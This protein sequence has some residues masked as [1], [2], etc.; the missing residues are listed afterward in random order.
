MELLVTTLFLAL[1]LV[2]SGSYHMLVVSRNWFSALAIPINQQSMGSNKTWRGIVVMMLATIPGVYLCHFLQPTL[3]DYLIVDM[4]LISPLWMGVLLGIGYVVPE[5]PN[6]YIKRKFNIKPGEQS[7]KYSFLF[8]F[9]DQADSAIGCAFVYGL[10]LS[11]PFEIMVAMI[12]LGPLLHVIA[13]ILL[14]S[15][16]LRKQPL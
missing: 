4:T 11:P 6:S 7:Q 5:L 1:P 16:G 14:Y 13:N 15:V 9:F 8:T 10:L 2:I 3:V 12:L